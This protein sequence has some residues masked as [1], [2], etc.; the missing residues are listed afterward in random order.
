MKIIKKVSSLV[1]LFVVLVGILSGCGSDTNKSQISNLADLENATIGII[2]G[3]N[4]DIVAQKNFPNAERMYFS[5][6]ADALLALDQGKIDTFF[7]DST[8]F[9]A[10]LWENNPVACIDEPLEAIDNALILAKEGYDPY[11][12]AQLNEF[13]GNSKNNGT[14]E[15][16]EEKW[17]GDTEPSEH[18]DNT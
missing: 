1:L 4:W 17:V 18:P 6:T 2:T 10:I 14:L 13:I 11:L 5:S 16:L 12:L 8:V 7:A 15:R 3:T 9:A